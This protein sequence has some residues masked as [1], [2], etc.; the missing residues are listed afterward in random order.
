MSV[1]DTW[2]KDERNHEKWMTEEKNRAN[3]ERRTQR[4]QWIGY[5]TTGMAVVLV[6]AI[7][8]GAV[9][10]W[11]YKDAQNN[12]ERDRACIAAGGTRISVNNTTM[13]VKVQEV[14]Q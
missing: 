10:F 7:I 1:D 4:N 9:L 3:R 5:V 14:Q 8:V 13:C 2:I 6:T 12:L 11:G